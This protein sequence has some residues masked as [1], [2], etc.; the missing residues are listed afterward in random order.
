MRLPNQMHLSDLRALI[1]CKVKPLS[2]NMTCRLDAYF[3][4]DNGVPCQDVSLKVG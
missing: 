2:R 4:P 3:P 1:L